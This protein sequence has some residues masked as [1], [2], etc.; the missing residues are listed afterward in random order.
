MTGVQTCALP[1]S[2]TYE[3]IVKGQ[4]IPT[5][6]IPESFKVLVKEL[7]SLCLDI[8]VLDAHGD[9]I[10][11]REDDEDEY[12]PYMDDSVYSSGD[13]EIEA[14]GYTIEDVE[15]SDDFDFGSDDEEVELYDD[16][17]EEDE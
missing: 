9:E 7:Q 2:K 6:G 8:K 1:I 10:E 16:Y 14:S 12:Q 11:L 17:D 5:P 3:A 13:D 15:E 4:N